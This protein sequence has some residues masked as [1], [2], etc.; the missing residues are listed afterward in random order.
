MLFFNEIMA[1]RGLNQTADAV[2]AATIDE[3]DVYGSRLRRRGKVTHGDDF[4]SL[5]PTEGQQIALIVG[6]EKISHHWNGW[7][8]P[9]YGQEPL[10]QLCTT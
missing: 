8:A 4:G 2:V 1:F 6:D 3:I 10:R 9:N 7:A 5:M